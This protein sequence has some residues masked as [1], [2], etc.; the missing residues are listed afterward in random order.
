MAGGPEPNGSGDGPGGLTRRPMGHIATTASRSSAA[1]FAAGAPSGASATACASWAYSFFERP[2]S[3]SNEETTTSVFQWRL[4]GRQVS[5][6][7]R[8]RAMDEAGVPAASSAVRA[9]G[10]EPVEAAPERALLE[11]ELITSGG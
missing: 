10:T 3:I 5:P 2:D 6:L 9:R 1:P 11:L 8:I 4:R 7:R